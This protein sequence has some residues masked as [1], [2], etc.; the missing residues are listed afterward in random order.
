MCD[1]YETFDDLL[2]A[3]D[4][5]ES[6]EDDSADSERKSSDIPNLFKFIFKFAAFV[7]IVALLS[8][9]LIFE[10]RNYQLLSTE[11]IIPTI[12]HNSSVNLPTTENRN[13]IFEIFSD[14]VDYPATETVPGYYEVTTISG[15]TGYVYQ[16]PQT[17]ATTTQPA[18]ITQH[19][20][21]VTQAPE[22]SNGL[23][24]INTASA[25]ELMTLNGIGEVKANAIIDYRNMNGRFNTVDELIFV[26]GIGEKTLEKIRP[27]VT[28]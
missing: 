10:I 6:G 8:A 25:S 21:T 20:S 7:V 22:P 11:S 18:A 2:A 27:Y 19:P 15:D 14:K 3:S 13:I 23:I 26:S 9:N 1:G 5:T 17:P 12:S 24:N 28:V 4:I 16:Q